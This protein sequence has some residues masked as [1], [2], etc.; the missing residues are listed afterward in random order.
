MSMTK[1]QQVTVGAGGAASIAFS[2]IPVFYTDLIIRVSGRSAAVSGENNNIQVRFN[3]AT[4]G[5]STRELFGTGSTTGSASLS[6]I[7]GGYLSSQF[8][9]ANTFGSSTIYIPN[10][11]SNTAKSVSAEGV[12][13]GNTTAMFQ[14]I[15]A[16][17][18]TG[19]DSIQSVTLVL[20]GSQNWLEGSSATLYGINRT[21]AIGRP[22][23]IGGNITYANG[24]WVHTFTGSG[25]FYAQ[26][27]L[28]LEYLVIA[29][30]GGGGYDRAAGGG[31]GG[32]RAYVAG[33][34]S[35]GNGTELPLSILAGQSRSV[36]V[37]A[38][39]APSTS[40]S[41]RPLTGSYSAFDSII[42]LGGGSAADSQTGARSGGS[43]GG[44]YGQDLGFG[45][46]GAAGASGQGFAGGNGT[47]F[48][49]AGGGGAGAV[50][51]NALSGSGGVGGIGVLSSIDGT[52]TY[53]GGGGGGAG[54]VQNGGTNGA[55]GLGGG[56][57]AGRP[58][59][60]GVANT[61]GGGG[62]G[63]NV[64]Q[65]SGGNGGSGVVIVRYR[66]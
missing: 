63:S 21:Q 42:S 44:G 33:E 10:Y 45:L 28:D 25:S 54:N 56:G 39:G 5:Y 66:A 26:E 1:I 27:D 38:G 30:G 16:G 46:L 65:Q 53:R 34:S 4:T 19:T 35:G 18:W 6:E 55:G 48:Q 3:G 36:V 22:K 40:Y 2:D 57:S 20:G 37:G 15:D 59:S 49:S 12:A 14:A 17:L 50:G 8:A 7:R 32:Y 43:G 58:G 9:T 51:G 29:G 23:A 31:A 11:R 41:T 13:E 24:Y 64:P 47:N 61:G 62:G 52:S 60:A